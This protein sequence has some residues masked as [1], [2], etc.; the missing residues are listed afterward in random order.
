[1][2]C[3]DSNSSF[4]KAQGALLLG[5]AASNNRKVQICALQTGIIPKLLDH[6]SD[7]YEFSVSTP[8]LYH[9]FI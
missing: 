1:M 5:S 8:V 7:A 3:I 4:L 9:V 6:F 2:P